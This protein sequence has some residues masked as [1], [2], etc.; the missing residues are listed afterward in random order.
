[1][2]IL[3]VNS[4]EASNKELARQLA[5]CQAALADTEALEIG[6]G[7]RLAKVEQQLAAAL[8]AC[9]LKD[10]EL[11]KIRGHSGLYNLFS[12]VGSDSYDPECADLNVGKCREIA[13]KALTIQP[14]DSA[15]KAWLGEPVAWMFSDNYGTHYTDDKREWYDGVG[16]ESVIPLYSPKG[17]K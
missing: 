16:I 9:K 10:E 2:N 3:Y 12:C 15:I 6:T 7:E 4:L 17:L 11:E 14:D 5:S 13:T 1:M 8:A